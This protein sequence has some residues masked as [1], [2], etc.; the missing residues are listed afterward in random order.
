MQVA[1]CVHPRTADVRDRFSEQLGGQH[2]VPGNVSAG[3]AAAA[4]V[5]DAR[6]TKAVSNYLVSGALVKIV[7][8][9]L[10]PKFWKLAVALLLL[11]LGV[12]ETN[13]HGAVQLCSA[14]GVVSKRI[15]GLDD[16]CGDAMQNWR[17]TGSCVY[18]PD[19]E[20]V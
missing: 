12:K 7:V 1:E 19:E 8:P 15:T 9:M 18:R 20:R 4:T 2:E 11:K 10:S 14:L 13:V 5:A 6:Y 16:K 17:S 3:R